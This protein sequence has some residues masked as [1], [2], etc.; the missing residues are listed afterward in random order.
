MQ[1]IPQIAWPWISSMPLFSS[2][3][4]CCCRSVAQSCPILCDP[5]DCSTP[6][7][8]LL[9]YFPELAQ[10][11]VH[12]VSN[13]IQPSH[14]LWCHSPPAFSLSQRQHLLSELALC[15]E[16]PKYWNFIFSI[17]PSNVYSGLIFFRIGWFDLLVV[18]GTL[19]SL[20]QHYSSKAS[21][22]QHSAFFMV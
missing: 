10:T 8:P 7:F 13:A 14:P 21:V 16:W 1:W 2:T 4:C 6:G 5:M 22:L 17:N 18:Q 11:Y 12:Q 9:Y 20:S 3:T 15:I 19:K